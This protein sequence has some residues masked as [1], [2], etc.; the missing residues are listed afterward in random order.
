MLQPQLNGEA[1]VR[2]EAKCSLCIKHRRD[3]HVHTS[4]GAIPPPRPASATHALPP[5][6]CQIAETLPGHPQG[7]ACSPDVRTE[8]DVP[9]L[10]P[11]CSPP[12]GPGWGD[13]LRR[14]LTSLFCWRHVK[15]QAGS[16]HAVYPRRQSF[17]HPPHRSTQFCGLLLHSTEKRAPKAA[18]WSFRCR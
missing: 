5:G 16:E 13:T 8:R 3:G 15:G 18:D 7:R 11:W 4:R 1:A 17:Y 9:G 14:A 12:T 6:F 2:Q 10:P